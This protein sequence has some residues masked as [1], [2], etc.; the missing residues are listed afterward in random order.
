VVGLSPCWLRCRNQDRWNDCEWLETSCP[1]PAPWTIFQFLCRC[2]KAG[3][4]LRSTWL[5]FG[6]MSAE[7]AIYLDSSAIVKLAVMEQE[8]SALRRYVRRRGPLVVSA[9]ARIEVARALLPLGPAAVERGIEVLR[10]I[11]VLRISDRVLSEAG[12]LLPVGLRSLDAIHLATMKQ[13]GPSLRRLVTYDARMAAAAA[14]MGI[15]THAP[16]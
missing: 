11:E 2:L 1:P 13:L 5:D 7:R 10:R 16:A 9:L 4:R 8:S 6:A 12:S 14:A 3:R 15:T